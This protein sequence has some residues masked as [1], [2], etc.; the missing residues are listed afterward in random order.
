M[1]GRQ[2]RRLMTLGVVFGGVAGATV[3]M[4]FAFSQNLLFFLTPSQ[5]AAGEAPPAR[6][7]RMG[8]MVAHGSVARGEGVAVRFVVTDFAR[9]VGV[10]YRGILPDL[11]REGQ[12]VVVRGRMQDEVFVAEEVLAKHDENYMPPEVRDALDAADVARAARSVQA[13]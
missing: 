5:V 3:L 1:T 2:K 6:V 8:G 13:E 7:F 4:L 9:E 12:G 10:A 11:F